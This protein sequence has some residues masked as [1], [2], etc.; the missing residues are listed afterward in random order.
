MGIEWE[1]ND[2]QTECLWNTYNGL[3]DLV[4][5]A[6]ENYMMKKE[7]I[8]NGTFK[9]Y[10]A[11]SISDKQLAEEEKEASDPAMNVK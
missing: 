5:I 2:V 1:L 10:S 11:E 8:A 6:H 7:M 9:N 3:H 4:K